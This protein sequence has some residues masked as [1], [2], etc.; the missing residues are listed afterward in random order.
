MSAAATIGALVVS[1]L[2]LVGLLRTRAGS[3]L[4]AQPSAERW[5]DTPTPTFG[6]VGIFAGLLA[7]VGAALAAGAVD[8]SPELAGILAGCAILF[9]AGLVD[10]LLRLSPV[11]KLAAQFAAAGVVVATGS[12]AELFD[13]ELLAGAVAFVW[14]VGI[15]NA[16]NL[17]DNMDGLAASLAAIAC[18]SFAVSAAVGP[19]GS[20]L[21]LVLALSLGF[22]CLSFLP[23]N[24]RPRRRAAVFMGDS[25]SQV[26]G[27]ALASL[28]LASSWDVA[29]ATLTS[30]VL[31]LLVLAVPILDTVLVTVVRLLERRPVS[32]GGKDHTSHR[33]VYSGLS[34]T[35]AVLALAGLAALLGASGLA[36][37]VLDDPRVTTVG[38]FVS[39]VVL[40]QFASALADLE[41]RSGGRVALESTSLR[42]LLWQPRRLLEIGVDFL[43]VCVSFLA[44]YLL[45]VGGTGSNY[46]RAVFLGALPVLLGLRYLAFVA[47]GV[48]RRVWRYAGVR[49]AAAVAIACAASGALALAAVWATRPLGDFPWEVFV[50]DALVCTVL[51]GASRLALRL[52]PAGERSTGERRRVVIVGAG[53][54]GRSL[55]RELRE[56][57]G[58][59]IV[60]FLD[61][62]EALRRRRVVGVLVRGGLADAGRV[63]TTL[64]AD[65]VLVTV[66]D[67]GPERLAAVAAAAREHG[68][69]YRVVRREVLPAEPPRLLEVAPE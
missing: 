4:V 20:E 17:L 51:V 61:D 68:V 9:A 37:T 64:R 57:G 23:F 34:E 24:L 26:L 41:E 52:L 27:F 5:H 54:S 8:P 25:G 59:R 36:Y 2:V 33:L 66:P 47:L 46:Q 60:G 58:H 28:G 50:V 40:V 49:D 22:A 13:N 18:A 6:G 1:A 69:E 16:F 63:L 42:A 10:D 56:T 29:G 35:R 7:G 30:L 15:A 65:E 43:L 39:F 31:P 11:A 19:D 44:S 48:Y 32:Q 21:V 55:A 45:L 67:A 38:V 3:V 53:R 14:L 12:R 62:N